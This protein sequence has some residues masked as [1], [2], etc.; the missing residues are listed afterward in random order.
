VEEP[1]VLDEDHIA[2]EGQTHFANGSG[3]SSADRHMLDSHG[4]PGKGFRQSLILIDE[5]DI[6]FNEENTFWPAVIALIRDSR[7]PVVLI[8]NGTS[9]PVHP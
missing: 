9:S 5:C 1:I 7:R 8:C 3:S 6:L 2:K 4:E